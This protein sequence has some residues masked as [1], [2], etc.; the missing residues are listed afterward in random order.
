MIHIPESFYFYTNIA[1]GVLY[2]FF[3]ISG[4]RRGFLLSVVTVI[5]SVMSFLAAWRYSPVANEYLRLYPRE[6]TPM[7]DT[8]MADQVYVFVNQIAWFLII[9]L[10]LKLVFFLIGRIAEGLQKVPVIRQISGILGA[11]L[12]AVVATF[13]VLAFCVVLNTPVFD[14][15]RALKNNSCLHVISDTAR[16]AVSELGVPVD[17]TEALNKLY[18]EAQNLSDEDR[19]AV[20]AWLDAHGFDKLDEESGVNDHE[21]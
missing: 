21:S 7:Q 3:L 19:E 5:G 10:V 20:S 11:G 12:G 16:A 13:W 2:L 4:Y 14:N 9:F 18:T 1:V 17:S 6:L 8:L 15:G